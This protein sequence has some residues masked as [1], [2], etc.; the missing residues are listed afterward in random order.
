MGAAPPVLEA[1]TLITAGGTVDVYADADLTAQRFGEYP[2]GTVLTVVEAGGDFGGYPVEVE[3]QRWY[4]VRAPDGLVGW[5]AE[6]LS[7]P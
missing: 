6:P 7:E 4:R 3:G 5:V 1:G 2:A